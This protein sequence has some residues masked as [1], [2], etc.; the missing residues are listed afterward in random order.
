MEPGNPSVLYAGTAHTAY[1]L[2][3]G[4]RRRRKRHLESTDGG[5]TWKNISAAK[6]FPKGTWGIVGVTVCP[7]NTDKI[8]ALIENAAGGLYVSN[9]AGESWTPQSSDNNIR[10]RAW[11]YTKVF[12]DPKNENIVYVL[13]VNFLKST[14]G[15]KHSGASAHRTAIITTCGLTLPM[16]TVR[17]LPMTAAPR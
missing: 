7:S 2:Q 6:G 5:E 3:F 9:D 15:G 10:Q 8:Y 1:A 17:V 4:K 13:N 16:A 11:Y 12:A 14:D